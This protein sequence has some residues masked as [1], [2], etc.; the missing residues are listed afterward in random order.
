[1]G[2]GNQPFVEDLS[3]ITGKTA[4]SRNRAIDS[5][6]RED[7]PNLRLTHQPQYS[8]FINSGLAKSGQGTHI[9]YKKFS[10]RESLRRVIV[11]EEL[12]HR[13]FKRGIPGLHHSSDYVPDE[14]FYRVIDRYFKMR[15][16]E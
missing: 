10:S 5:L 15:G 13:W 8:P 2:K 3:H 6:I 11:H 16:W 14:K 9:G 1:M 12:H 7:L 4:A